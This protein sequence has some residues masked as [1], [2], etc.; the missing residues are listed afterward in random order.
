MRRAEL[1]EGSFASSFGLF[2]SSAVLA[3][4]RHIQH[5]LRVR[6]HRRAAAHFGLRTED[7][8]RDGSE[9][10]TQEDCQRGGNRQFVKKSAI[11][12]EV[13]LDPG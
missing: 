7:A 8:L 6:S 11:P 10:G 1:D 4:D 3:S 2:T 12:N 9:D 5:H 13:P